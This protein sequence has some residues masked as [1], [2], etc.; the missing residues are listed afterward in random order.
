MKTVVIAIVTL[1]FMASISAVH[2]SI[3]KAATFPPVHKDECKLA[4]G[5]LADD[6][7]TGDVYCCY[8][9]QG[10]AKCVDCIPEDVI[11]FK[12]KSQPTVK[13]PRSPL[14]RQYKTKTKKAQL[15]HRWTKGKGAVLR[16]VFSLPYH[17]SAM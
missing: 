2:V 12:K 7:A 5:T 17:L 8:P 10:C 16:R 4:G 6:V 3:S 13:V 14:K 11:V 1:A 9:D 15:P